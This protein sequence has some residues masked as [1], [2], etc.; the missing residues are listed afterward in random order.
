MLVA[1]AVCPATPLLVPEVASGA[2]GELAGLRAACGRALTGLAAAR[3]D[4]LLVVGPAEPDERGPH[5]QGAVGSFRPFGVDLTV[6]LGEP[7]EGTVAEPAGGARRLP[8]A[9]AV[10][11]WLLGQRGGWAGPCEGLGVGEPLA[12]SECLRVGRELAAPPG[13][14]A[15]LVM[16]DGSACREPGSPR[17]E[18]ARAVAFDER[19]AAALAAADV[20]ALAGIDAE[21]AAELQ[22]AG[23]APWQV[24]AGAAADARL[25]GRLLCQDAPY[26][27]GYFVA[28]WS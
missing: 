5:A 28:L 26:G 20:E 1:A 21:L 19:V 15:L 23:R 14:L 16:G 10:A 17:A 13:R 7:A 25:T 8:Y 11:A 3:P 6:R 9:L 12:P 22:V 2:A 27:V 4:R 24:L 18:D